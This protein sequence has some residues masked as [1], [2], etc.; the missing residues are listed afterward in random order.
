MDFPLLCI[1]PPAPGARRPGHNAFTPGGM[2][3]ENSSQN[4]DDA[5]DEVQQREYKALLLE[6]WEHTKQELAFPTQAKDFPLWYLFLPIRIHVD[7]NSGGAV[8][9]LTGTC[10]I[11]NTSKHTNTSG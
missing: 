9:A 5:E 10:R 3:G 2:N 11:T 4:T 6:R 1:P 7:L 8:L